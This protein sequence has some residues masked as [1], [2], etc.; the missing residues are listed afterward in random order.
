[1][2][3]FIADI[4]T[5]KTP[6]LTTLVLSVT[7]ILLSTSFSSSSRVENETLI[8]NLSLSVSTSAK[9][10]FETLETNEGPLDNVIISPLSI[11]LAMSLLY[12]GAE[13]DSKE[14]IADVMSFLNISDDSVILKESKQLLESYGEL[15]KNLTTNIELANSAFTD[16]RTDLKDEYESI[17]IEYFLTK[18]RRV[19]FSQPDESAELI[20]DWV[21][22]KTNN[23]IKDL[24]SPG[25]LSPDTRL[26]LIN[27][28]YFKANWQLPFEHDGTSEETFFVDE[29]VTLTA[30]MM[31]QEN[32]ILYGTVE[33]LQSQVVS[34]Q[35]E[36]PNFTMI[37]FLPNSARSLDA[38]SKKLIEVDFNSIH[39]SLDYRKLLLRMPKFKLGCKTE[40][41]STLKSL[42]VVDIFDAALANLTNN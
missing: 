22:N 13:E 11:H 1:M 6:I 42:G 31:V 30:D 5:M 17:L 29:N 35:Y 4:L 18:T 14:Q 12:H 3:E 19:N 10:L 2:G 39:E 28:V 16:E 33:D 32:E 36:D 8:P 21:A 15:K 41:V 38:L 27:A 24:I 34:L 26:M 20:N 25:S 9:G 7:Q 37:V 40:L 23:L